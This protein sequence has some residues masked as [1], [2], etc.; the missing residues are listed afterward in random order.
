[1][2]SYLTSRGNIYD[3]INFI[4]KRI[5]CCCC[6]KGRNSNDYNNNCNIRKQSSSKIQ[7]EILAQDYTNLIVYFYLFI[8]IAYPF[9]FR[10]YNIMHNSFIHLLH[11]HQY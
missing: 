10:Y 5:C 7:P 11:N 4:I 8:Y 2:F 3:F 1:M 9:L 6:C